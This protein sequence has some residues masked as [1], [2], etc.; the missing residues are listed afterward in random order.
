LG[1]KQL[2]LE[3]LPHFA[4]AIDIYE[5]EGFVRLSKPLGDSKH[6]TCSIWMLKELEQERHQA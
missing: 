5:K 4:K 3:S 6:K 2:Y 1:Y